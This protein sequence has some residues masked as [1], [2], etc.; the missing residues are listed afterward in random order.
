MLLLV[1]SRLGF[2][3]VECRSSANATLCPRLQSLAT[4]GARLDAATAWD[5][6]VDAALNGP[7]QVSLKRTELI[8]GTARSSV[9]QCS[10]IKT[11]LNN[12]FKKVKAVDNAQSLLLL[13]KLVGH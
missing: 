8:N 2:G 3:A 10:S 4:A 6:L 5:G 11:L 9:S 12:F 13:S 1:S 7:R